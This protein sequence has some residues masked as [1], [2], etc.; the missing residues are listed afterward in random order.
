[1]RTAKELVSLALS[2]VGTCEDP[3]GSNKQ[4]YGAY[5]DDT[6]W[7]LYKDGSKT[8]V[9]KVNGYDWCTQFVDWCFCFAFGI[10]AAREMLFRPVYN[11]Y[12]AGAV[13]AYD[14][15]KKAGAVVVS[16]Q[17]GDV[18]YFQRKGSITHTGIIIEVDAN[19]ITTIEGNAGKN[20]WYVVKNKYA[21]SDSY[22]YGY[23]RPAYQESKYP[24][25]PFQ[26]V[27]DLK[28]VAIR[29]GPYSDCQII[30][31][32]SFGAVVDIEKLDGSSGDFGKV[33]GYVY[34]PGGFDI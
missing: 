2:Q 15:F 31:Y 9:H 34:L 17:P 7:Y 29:S 5:L 1:M 32:I 8:W 6:N 24:D 10:D 3:K 23:G 21:K 28:G 30:G 13:Y 27:N 25:P 18:V 12:G 14:Y 19:Y 20:N 26:A 4:P 16:P 22:V 11:N 33:T